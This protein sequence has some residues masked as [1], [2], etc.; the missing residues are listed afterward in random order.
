MAS[1]RDLPAQYRDQVLAILSGVAPDI[2]VWA[3]GS[4]V[5]GGAFE[6]S[7]WTLYSG[8]RLTLNWKRGL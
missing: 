3:Y 1:K 8:I 6:A 7:V 4:R 5:T 2:E